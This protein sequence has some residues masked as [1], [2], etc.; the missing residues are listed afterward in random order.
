MYMMLGSFTTAGLGAD[1]FRSVPITIQEFFQ[2][3]LLALRCSHFLY[4]G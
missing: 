1:T 2:W 3:A 4:E